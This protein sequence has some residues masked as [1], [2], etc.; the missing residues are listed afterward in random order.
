MNKYLIV[1]AAGAGAV[2][3]YVLYR[4]AGKAVEVLGDAAHA[5]NPMNNNNVINRSA[6]DIYQTAF[7]TQGTIG[8]D[9]YD[10]LHG[11]VLDWGGALDPSSDNNLINRGANGAYTAATGSTG[12]IGSDLYDSV[13]AIENWWKSW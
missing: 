4:G 5:I 2:L 9:L 3:A 13:Q 8:T 1:G 7:G 11:G 6:T 12:S 10:A